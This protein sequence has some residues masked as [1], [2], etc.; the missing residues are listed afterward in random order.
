MA[1]S[2]DKL[3]A[4]PSGP[5]KAATFPRRPFSIGR[6]LALYGLY[7][8]ALFIMAGWLLHIHHRAS[9]TLLPR[10]GEPLWPYMADLTKNVNRVMLHA[11][12]EVKLVI[13]AIYMSVSMTFLPLNTTAVI[14][15]LAMRK[16]GLAGNFWATTALIALI[17]G[18]GSMMANIAD[19]GLLR[20]VLQQ[21]RIAKV[22]NTRLYKWAEHI[23]ERQPFELL[24][25]FNIVP[26][27]VDVARLLAAA[28]GY[29][30]GRFAMASI[31][32]RSIRYAIIA[33]ITYELGDK[34]WI[35]PVVLLGVAVLMPLEGFV[36]KLI[37]NV[38]RKKRDTEQQRSG[39][40][41]QGH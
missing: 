17:G 11:A 27:P 20:L 1:N 40:S 31:V 3:D 24:L 37:V 35:S 2:P 21:P 32:G 28:E 22:K 25:F 34:G 10:S 4:A 38:V 33:A 41:S 23:F 7:L 14:G 6:W 15:W 12:V 26:F 19:Y 8:L 5:E 9:E 39:T 36:R 30:I 18:F 16:S 29:P 13:F